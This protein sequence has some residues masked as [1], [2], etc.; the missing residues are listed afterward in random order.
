MTWLLIALLPPALWSITNHID[1]YLLS[2]YF[3]EGSVGALMV[4]SSLIGVILLPIIYFIHPAVI[5]SFNWSYLLISINGLFYLSAVLPYFYALQKDETSITVPLFQMIPVYSFVLGYLFLG[6]KLTI[7]QIIGG[8]I[9]LLGALFIS[10]EIETIKH[11]KLKKDVFLLMTLSS[12]LYSINFILFKFF[13]IDYNFYITSFWEYVGFA[14]FAIILILFIKK[15]RNEFFKVIKVNSIK[16]VSVNGINEIINIIAKIAF[17]FASLIVPVTL[18]W[19]VNGS[20]PFFVFI[21]GIILTL[22]FPKFA[23]EDLSKK[24]LLQKIIA[25]FVMFVGGVIINL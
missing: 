6:E 9:I 16:V 18:V 21:F 13:A 8:L 19:I 12:L 24:V 20:Q 25:I 1:K 22:L 11:F 3:K 2:K 5:T 7:M 10:L 4:F 17:N 23:K 15:Y 14:F